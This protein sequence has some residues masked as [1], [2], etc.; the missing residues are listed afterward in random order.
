MV[1]MAVV[2]SL[3]MLIIG[4][5]I[6]RAFSLVGALSIIRFRNAVK[7]SRDVAFYFL[8]MAVGMAAGTHYVTVAAAFTLL[9]CPMIFYLYRFQVGAKTTS[10]V[11]LRLTMDESVEYQHAFDE[12][13]YKY[14]ESS[15]L[16]SIDGDGSGRQ[17]LVYTV[18]LRRRAVEQAFL[19]DLRN[20]HP[21]IRTQ[22]IH[23]VRGLPDSGMSGADRIRAETAPSPGHRIHGRGPVSALPA[24]LSRG[25]QSP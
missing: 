15:D 22:L 19:S 16:L 5:N 10:E 11:L 12:V 13:F 17:E 9:I 20:V 2:V 7:E 6:A 25:R 1:I 8:A 21:S 18:S 23:C 4:S 24:H 3:I 14:L